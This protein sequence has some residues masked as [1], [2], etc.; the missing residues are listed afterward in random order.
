MN[1]T[2]EYPGTNTCRVWYMT[3]AGDHGI[4]LRF[5]ALWSE[6]CVAH[7]AEP[8]VGSHPFSRVT[9]IFAGDDGRKPDRLSTKD[10]D[11]LSGPGRSR[12]AWGLKPCAIL[13]EW[14][15][16]CDD[17][18]WTAAEHHKCQKEALSLFQLREQMPQ[19][20]GIESE[21]ALDAI[22]C[23][24]RLEEI[25]EVTGKLDSAALG[26]VLATAKALLSTQMLAV[27]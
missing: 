1:I 7:V 19:T 14:V 10:L 3:T 23:R 5:H 22:R 24:D 9:G 21:Q 16:F 8:E 18:V 13:Q 12:A 6:V 17:V 26:K 4:A 27:S 2:I 11:T 25:S 20:W 15:D